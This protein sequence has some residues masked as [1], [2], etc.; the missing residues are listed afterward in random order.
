MLSSRHRTPPAPTSN[1]L[2]C[3]VCRKPVYSKAG[4]HPQCAV[5]IVDQP[6]PD[7][8]PTAI[9]KPGDSVRGA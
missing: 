6:L 8:D 9:A 4:I 7:A 2:Q 5:K 1:R 3:P